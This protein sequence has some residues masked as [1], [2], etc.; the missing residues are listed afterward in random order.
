MKLYHIHKHNKYDDMF[1]EGNSFVV[2]N[3]IN[4]LTDD[5]LNRS[6]SYIHHSDVMDGNVCD[7]RHNLKEL[8]DIDLIND[9]T[10]EQR[11]ELFYL[12]KEYII[13]SQID[14]REL[15]LEEVRYKHFNKLPSRRSCIWL[16]DEESL[17]TWCNLLSYKD[18]DSIF[19]V[20]ADG[21]IFVSTDK[22]L[23]PSHYAH[24]LMYKCAFNYWN[25]KEEDLKDAK[26][27]EYLFEGNL[28]ILR[29]VK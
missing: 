24:D 13:N 28:K 12:V 15:I 29:R 9:M 19:E 14:F 5:F 8:L 10:K 25:P 27:K 20:E 3:E 22:L 4:T 1:K 6:S 21:N 7:Y 11:R 23:P 16:T 2:G 18:K 26:D 17:D